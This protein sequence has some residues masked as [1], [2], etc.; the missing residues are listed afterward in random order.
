MN[1]IQLTSSGTLTANLINTS[2]LI[3]ANAGLTIPSGQ[4]LTSSGT[5]TANGQIVRLTGVVADNVKTD[6]INMVNSL[7]SQYSIKFVQHRI[8]STDSD[9]IY[10]KLIMGQNTPTLPYH[11]E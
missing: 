2:G 1:I 11:L 6:L 5:L 7:T 4:T 3:T 10:N 8:T 9:I